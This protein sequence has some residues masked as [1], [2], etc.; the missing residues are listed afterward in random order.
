ME[1]VNHILIVDDSEVDFEAIVREIKRAGIE[2]VTCRCQD[3]NNFNELVESQAWD[4]I[5]CDHFLPGFSSEDVLNELKKS[6]AAGTPFLIVSGIIDPVSAGEIIRHGASCYV[7]KDDLERL[8]PSLIRELRVSELIRANSKL[9]EQLSLQDEIL[10]EAQRE[11]HSLRM[12][13]HR[14]TESP[15][16]KNGLRVLVVD[17]EQWIGDLL[18]RTLEQMGHTPHVLYDACEAK[19]SLSENKFDLVVSDREMPR[20][21][22]DELAVLVREESPDTKFMM[23]TAYGELMT[24]A[25]EVPEGVDL[26]I[27]KPISTTVLTESLLALFPAEPDIIAIAG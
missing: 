19:K 2:A 12:E 11:I 22:G 16:V 7:Y 25:D 17:D 5:I 18:G 1:Q 26:V 6:S 23:V 15:R 20:M 8:G 4:A 3:L 13:L 21:N 9:R 10:S 24:E 14:K 27:P